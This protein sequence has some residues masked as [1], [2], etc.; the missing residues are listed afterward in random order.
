MKAN[1]VI[2]LLAL[3]L[4]ATLIQAAETQ[5]SSLVGTVQSVMGRPDD[6]LS[7]LALQHRVGFDELV[8]ANPSLNPFFFGEVTKVT[9]PT[10]FLLPNVEHDGIVINLPE[11]RLYF[12]DKGAVEI[13]PIGIGRAGWSTPVA[14]TVVT[15]RLENPAWFPPASIRAE[16]E[17]VGKLLPAMVPAGPDN[18]LGNHAL[19][20][21]LPGYLLHGTNQ[22]DGVGM[23]VSHGCIRLYDEH[24]EAL[25]N[26]VRPGTRVQ[27]I[28]QP[29]KWAHV[30]GQLMI[31]AHQPLHEPDG[32]ANRT[33]A[34][35]VESAGNALQD[36]DRVKAFVR[37]QLARHQLFDGLPKIIP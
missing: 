28:N 30:D 10:Q 35:S 8:A 14:D 18:P 24:I 33:F 17:A 7:T 1:S 6:T 31:E 3:S 26:R 16:H 37:D 12:F 20:L 13:Y 23:R 29:V 11:L 2:I 19:T 4:S 36:A 21:A 25:F 34:V 22:P 5:G 15:H 32:S 9:L 27:I